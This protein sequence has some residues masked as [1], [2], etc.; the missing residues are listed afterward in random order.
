MK[1]FLF[2]QNLFA[3]SIYGETGE[4]NLRSALA[5]HAN[6]KDDSVVANTTLENLR[7]VKKVISNIHGNQSQSLGLYPAFYFYT[8]KGQYKDSRSSYSLPGLQK[9]VLMKSY[10]EKSEFTL[11]RDLFE[12][13]WM[14][15]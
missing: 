13:V 3:I 1:D 11:A 15:V 8:N 14:L 6:E 12:E 9:E 4:E 7:L 2:L 5:N 10:I